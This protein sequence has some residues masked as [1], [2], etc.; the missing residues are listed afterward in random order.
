MRPEMGLIYSFSLHRIESIFCRKLKTDIVL[1]LN[2]QSSSSTTTS[3]ILINFY[4]RFIVK[5]QRQ[6][7]ELPST[8]HPLPQLLTS[9]LLTMVRHYKGYTLSKRLVTVDAILDYLAERV[10]LRSLHCTVSLFLPSPHFT[11]WK[12][13]T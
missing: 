1:V 6:H 13:V 3:F 8:S 2:L 5:F 10:V 7:R 4:S 11:F 12:E 9:Y